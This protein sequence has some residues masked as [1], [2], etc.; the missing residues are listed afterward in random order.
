[1]AP[2]LTPA[3]TVNLGGPIS[4]PLIAGGR[5]FV[6]VGNPIVAGS[7]GSKLYALNAG[8]GHTLWGPIAIGGSEW[9]S[10]AA[11]DAGMVFVINYDGLMRAYNAASGQL[12]W[13]TQLPSPYS[14][15]SPPTAL[16]GKVYVAGGDAGGEV[17]ALDETSGSVDWFQS[18]VGYGSTSPAVT[19]T[20]VYLSYSPAQAYDLRPSDGGVVWHYNSGTVS[21]D[22]ETPVL[23]GNYLYTRTSG[24]DQILNATTGKV[25]GSR[26]ISTPPVVSG[27]VGYYMYGGTLAAGGLTGSATNWSFS[28]NDGLTTAPVMLNGYLYVGSYFGTL[29]A[30]DPATGQQVWSTNVNYLIPNPDEGDFEQPLAGMGAAAGLFV[31]P[32]GQELVAYTYTQVLFPTAKPVINSALAASGTVGAGFSYQIAA[33]QTPSSFTAGTPPAGLALDKS[34]GLISGTPAASGTFK[35]AIGAVNSFGTGTASLTISIYPEAPVVNGG[36]NVSVSGTG[37]FPFDY[38]VPAVN[39]PTSFTAGGLPSGLAIDPDTGVISGTPGVTGTFPVT[40]DAINHTGTGT[41]IVSIVLATPPAPVID[42][43]L[44]VTG[45]ASIPFDYQIGASNYPA[46][47]TASGLPA[48]LSLDPSNGLISGTLVGTGTY[49]VGISALNLGGSDSELLTISVTPPPP[50]FTTGTVAGIVGTPFSYQVGAINSPSSFMAS[51]LPPGLGIDPSTGLI[52]GTPTSSGLFVPIVSATNVY[53]SGSTSLTLSIAANPTAYHGTFSGLGILESGPAA[54]IKLTLNAHGSFT[55]RF[56]APGEA[57]TLAGK[58]QPFGFAAGSARAGTATLTYQ[59]TTNSDPPGIFGYV[60]VTSTA[61]QSDY[62]IESMLLGTFNAKTL[63]AGLAGHYTVLL[64][65]TTNGTAAGL[66]AGSGFGTM[67]VTSAGAIHL[68]GKMADGAPFAISS[69]L[70]TDG[71]TYTLFDIPYTAAKPGL[72][73][74]EMAFATSSA[75]DASGFVEWTRPAGISTTLYPAGFAGVCGIFAAKYAAPALASG[76]G[77]IVLSDG[78]LPSSPLI[79]DFTVSSHGA[80]AFGSAGLTLSIVPSTGAFTGRFPFPGTNKAT[81]YS[82]VIYQKPT[83]YGSGLFLSSTESGEVIISQ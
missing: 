1:M 73:A 19:T 23:F 80:V 4:Y 71:T 32:A 62:A 56:A 27:T 76:T 46:S 66:P 5:V 69:Q 55:G 61:G 33:T 38:Q 52:S 75:S 34:T 7:E 51:G 49:G 29:Y 3:W 67:L 81:V 39:A 74:G 40:V 6:T 11:Y 16:N 12:S 21:F 20:G 72:V 35:V 79:E 57:F 14:Y 41:A 15:T 77:E 36:S 70:Q 48:G 83:T 25:V 10:A 44:N 13:S 31:V 58:F 28:T 22:G 24:T 8:D 60:V 53:G 18:I 26:Y 65:V 17:Y 68:S 9:F 42:S 64:P 63:P 43:E 47:Y 2:A 45:Y 78:D 30:L 82:G 50:V 59:F 54:S 37:D